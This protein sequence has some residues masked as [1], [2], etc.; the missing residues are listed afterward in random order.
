MFTRD[1]A[2]VYSQLG[3]YQEAHDSLHR[4]LRQRYE[5]QN[6]LHWLQLPGDIYLGLKRRD[7]A[8]SFYEKIWQVQLSKGDAWHGLGIS[9]GHLERE[10]EAT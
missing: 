7:E 10:Q 6:N 9:L 3:R 1:S 5:P 8:R 4:G 2:G